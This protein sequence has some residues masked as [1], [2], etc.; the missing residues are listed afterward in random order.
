ML[1]TKNPPLVET[2]SGPE[3]IIGYEFYPVYLEHYLKTYRSRSAE[4]F[5]KAL[6][7]FSSA[8]RER[9]GEINKQLRK[10]GFYPGGIDETGNIVWCIATRQERTLPIDPYEKKSGKLI[11]PEKARAF[12]RLLQGLSG[13]VDQ[14]YEDYK[15]MA[16][17]E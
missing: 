13:E 3:D 11:S 16:S 12:T 15:L 14:D 17:G 10:H 5:T 6:R 4:D 2:N 8:N 9:V 7:G 1:T